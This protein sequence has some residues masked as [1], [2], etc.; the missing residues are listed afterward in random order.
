MHNYHLRNNKEN[1]H[2]AFPKY[3]RLRNEF[4]Q[5]LNLTRTPTNHG[6]QS[7]HTLLLYDSKALKNIHQDT[8]LL[9]LSKHMTNY[10]HH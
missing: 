1:S 6:F 5:G 9:D 4:L 7:H 2:V 8:A 10:L 3:V